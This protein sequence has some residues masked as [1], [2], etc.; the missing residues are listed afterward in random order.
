MKKRSK[1]TTSSSNTSTLPAKE[2]VG[3]TEKIN[4]T[5]NVCSVNSVSMQFNVIVLFLLIT[6]ATDNEQKLIL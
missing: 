2:H 3:Y 6:Y 4:V 1:D 5:K